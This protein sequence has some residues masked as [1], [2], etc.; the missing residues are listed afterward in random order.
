LREHRASHGLSLRE[1]EAQTRLI[2]INR[3]LG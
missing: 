1:I 3:N 2:D